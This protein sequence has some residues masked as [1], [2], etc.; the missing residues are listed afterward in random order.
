M[1]MKNNFKLKQEIKNQICVHSEKLKILIMPLSLKDSKDHKELY[2]NNILFAQL[3]GLVTL[4]QKKYFSEWNQISGLKFILPYTIKV[5]ITIILCCVMFPIFGQKATGPL[6]VCPANTRYFT[7]GSGKAIYLT[8]SH[9]WSNFATDQGIMDP[10]MAFDYN[11]YL[12]FMVAHNHNFF[13]G[14]LWELTFSVQAFNGGPFYWDPFPW[15]RTGPGIATDGKPRF[16][17]DKYNKEYFDRIRKRVIAARDH[18][19]YVSI[20]LFQGYAIQFNRTDKDGYPLDGRNNINGIDCGPGY[21]S[22]TLQIPQVTAKQDEYVKKV[23]DAVNDL[24]NVLYEISNESGS[25]STDWQY[26]MIDLIHKY[27]AGKPKQH[28]VGMT[29]LYK[30]GSNDELFKSNADWISP[31]GTSGYGYTDTNPPAADGRKVVVVDTDHSYFWV[32]LKKD[33]LSAQQAWVWKNFLRGNNTLFMDPYLAKIKIRNNPDGVTADPDFGLNP[34]PYWETIRLAMGRTRLYAQKI[35]LTASTPQ[36]TLSST[37]YC[38]ANPGNEYLV[39]NPGDSISFKVNLLRGT[40]NFEWFNPTSGIVV[41]RGSFQVNDSCLYFS[42]PFK[43]DA[44]LH[45]K[46]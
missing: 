2:F 6:K 21:L 41:D 46:K 28:P 14:W 8:G 11:G 32:G 26:H 16:N 23:I 25:Y 29:F 13:R 7:D 38:L 18:G 5:I 37:S 33:G 35:D 17:L 30:G 44:V 43:G 12:D 4:W 39:Y 31:D 24:D 19:I 1:K 20:M 9:S 34:D 45:I 10:P 22:N 40:Y 3:R 42:A 27:E 15:Q 36:N